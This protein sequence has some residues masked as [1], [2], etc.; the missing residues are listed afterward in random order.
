[1]LVRWMRALAL[2]AVVLFGWSGVAAAQS[3]TYNFMFTSA[4]GSG[5]GL[6]TATG[7]AIQSVSDFIINGSTYNLDTSGNNNF[8]R[9]GTNPMFRQVDAPAYFPYD[10]SNALFVSNGT[11]GYGFM[12]QNSAQD[13]VFHVSNT[14]GSYNRLTGLAL[15]DTETL[16]PA[17]PAPAPAPGGGLLSWLTAAL[18]AASGY[19][20]THVRKRREA[21]PLL[22]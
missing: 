19:L 4:A 9:A 8:Q 13:L 5:G 21:Q 18:V 2:A 7:G 3:T 22:A 12:E 14:G 15:A 20:W 6:I 10:F 11:D 17:A 1:M 16:G